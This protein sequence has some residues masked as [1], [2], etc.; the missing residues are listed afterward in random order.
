MDKEGKMGIGLAG[1]FEEVNTFGGE[2]M[3]NPELSGNVTAKFQKAQKLP[4]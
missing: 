1:L 4:F 3:G 2:T